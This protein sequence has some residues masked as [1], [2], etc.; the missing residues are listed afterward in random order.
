[1][2]WCLIK[3][4]EKLNLLFTFMP[5]I[6][7]VIFSHMKHDILEGTLYI[8]MYGFSTDVFCHIHTVS[9]VLTLKSFNLVLK[10]KL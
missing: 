8:C 7:K 5:F 9:G 10:Y 4:K 3:H 6:N 1:M 2:I